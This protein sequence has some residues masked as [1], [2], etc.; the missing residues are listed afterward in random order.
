MRHRLIHAYCEIN[1]DIL[2]ETVVTDLPPLIA[3]L[4]KVLPTEAGGVFCRLQSVCT[5]LVPSPEMR[6]LFRRVPQ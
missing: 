1:L 2:W 5:D 6:N 4:E 3:S